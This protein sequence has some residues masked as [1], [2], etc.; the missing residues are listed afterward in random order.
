MHKAHFFVVQPGRY[1]LSLS[2][3]SFNLHFADTQRYTKEGS[4]F[5]TIFR[6]FCPYEASILARYTKRV[7]LH[8]EIADVVHC[9]ST[10]S[11]YIIVR[12]WTSLNIALHIPLRAQLGAHHGLLSLIV[13]RALESGVV[14][15]SALTLYFYPLSWLIMIKHTHRWKENAHRGK[16]EWSRDTDWAISH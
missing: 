1:P 6:P 7:S 12:H 3:F 10:A 13:S 16:R 14:V 9:G 8:R 5:A 15:R 11:L 4:L 2:M